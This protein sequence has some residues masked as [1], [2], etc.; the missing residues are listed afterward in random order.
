M[1][2]HHAALTNPGFP[3]AVEDH[4]A[5]PGSLTWWFSYTPLK[6]LTAGTEA[7]IVFFVL[8][9][10]VV[11]L[12]VLRRPGFDWIA[13]FP[14]RVVRLGVPV[15]ASV[16]LAAA[17]VLAIPQRSLSG[18]SSW[19]RDSSTPHL[20]WQL[21]VEAVDRL[22]GDAHINNPLWSLRWELLFSLALP[23]FVV[24]AVAL[25]RWWV[26]CIAGCLLLT[27]LGLEGHSA[28]FQFLPAFFVGALLA[29]RMD[30]VRGFAARV[31]ARR[32]RHLVWAGITVGGA[33]LLIASWFTGLLPVH[34][35]RIALALSG[36]T[37][38]AAAL[39]IVA[40]IGWDPLRGL[41]SSRPLQFVGRISF[42][43]YLVHVPILIFT[44]YLTGGHSWFAAVTLG[45]ALSLLVATGF[46]WLLESPSHGWARRAGEW[47]S[48]CYAAHVGKPGQIAGTAT[49][50]GIRESRK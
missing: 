36:L 7:V 50:G 12:P 4:L 9:G 18:A 35:D 27:W 16:L 23:A 43:L 24:L 33:M 13:Y 46:W 30:A 40:A 48:R 5:S 10:L 32:R 42:S 11:T 38:A 28:G 26:A 22:G 17:F 21:L 25:R 44:A 6:L 14:R 47:A 29:V 37:P 41:L 31:N 8:S 1:L 34:D 3:G 39:L 45:A 49:L 15:A 20:S 2:A 19:L